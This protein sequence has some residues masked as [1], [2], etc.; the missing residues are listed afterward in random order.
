MNP[1]VDWQ[2]EATAAADRGRRRSD[3]CAPRRDPA[4]R[5]GGLRCVRQRRFPKRPAA[6]TRSGP[7][8]SCSRPMV[9]WSWVSAPAPT[10]VT[11]G[12]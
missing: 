4:A 1:K 11:R 12:P 10:T 7:S 6:A 8:G 2:A 5:P 3:R 9:S